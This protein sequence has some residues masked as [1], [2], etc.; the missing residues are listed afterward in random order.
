M[1]RVD[2]QDGAGRETMSEMLEQNVSGSFNHYKTVDSPPREVEN[3]GSFAHRM[4]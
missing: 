2:E 4:T 3:L 1:I